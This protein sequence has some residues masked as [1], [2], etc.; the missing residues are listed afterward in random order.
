MQDETLERHFARLDALSPAGSSFGFHIR[1]SR[2]LLTRSRY[3]KVWIRTYTARTYIVCDPTVIWAVTNEGSIRWSEVDLPDTVGLFADAERH[4]LRFGATF[5]RGEGNSRTIGNC[6]RSDREF[7]DA[8]IRELEQVVG[9]IHDHLGAETNLKTTQT[10]ALQALADGLTYDEACARLGISRT[11]LRNRL[12][13]ARHALL[14]HDNA[15]AVRLAVVTGQID[16]PT[17]ADLDR[18]IPR[19]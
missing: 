9:A 1:F 16:S 6:A 12:K 7:T 18:G 19:D 13:G 11:A 4:G 10:E 8:E 14:A 17:Y 15:E 5:S 3:D 2:P